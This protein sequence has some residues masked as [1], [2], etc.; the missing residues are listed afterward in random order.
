MAIETTVSLKLDKG[1][2]D[3]GLKEVERSAEAA[4]AK[5]VAIGVAAAA[6]GVAAGKALKAAAEAAIDFGKDVIDQSVLLTGLSEKILG[7]R[8]TLVTAI[9]QGFDRAANV[10][11][12]NTMLDSW[13]GK[14]KEWG[15][16][17]GI[18]LADALMGQTAL[19]TRTFAVLGKIA[20]DV[21]SAPFRDFINQNIKQVPGLE[22]DEATAKKLG[23]PG[24]DL[25]PLITPETMEAIKALMEAMRERANRLP[26]GLQGEDI[27]PESPYMAEIVER[28]LKSFGLGN[29]P[30]VR[31]GPGLMASERIM[32]PFERRNQMLL[33][34]IEK[35]TREAIPRENTVPDGFLNLQR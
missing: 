30:Q 35:N 9:G 1:K 33:E 2:V 15:D 17:I 26:P 34:Q 12:I 27:R 22:Y 11:A 31:W 16:G 29:L 21:F 25:A 23:L 19:L 3:R 4:Q 5:F 18:A 10:E 13:T 14:L 7:L 20:F 28:T 32:D 6:V 24:K 8:E